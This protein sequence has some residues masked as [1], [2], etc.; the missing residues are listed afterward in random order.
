MDKWIKWQQHNKE[1]EGEIEDALLWGTCT[2][3]EA[4]LC[5]LKVDLV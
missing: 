4:V 2:T 5:Y 1:Q 3:R